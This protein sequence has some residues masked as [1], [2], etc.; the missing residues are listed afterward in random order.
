MYDRELAL[1]A[2]MVLLII[3]AYGIL[4]LVEEMGENRRQIV[5]CLVKNDAERVAE[6]DTE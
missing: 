1:L 5:V 6:H 2:V 3:I 4:L